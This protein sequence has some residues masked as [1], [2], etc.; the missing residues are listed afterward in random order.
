MLVPILIGLAV[1]FWTGYFV[2]YFWNEIYGWFDNRWG[3]PSR[4][5]KKT[6]MKRRLYD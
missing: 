2:V 5:P 3:P 6:K 4:P 1:V